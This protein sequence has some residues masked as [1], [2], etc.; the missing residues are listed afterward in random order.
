MRLGVEAV[1]ALSLPQ[2]P[3]ILGIAGVF[4]VVIGTSCRWESSPQLAARTPLFL[5]FFMPNDSLRFNRWW[6]P[7]LLMCFSSQDKCKLFVLITDSMHWKGSFWFGG[8]LLIV[9]ARLTKDL[10]WGS[11]KRKKKLRCSGSWSQI[12]SWKNKGGYRKDPFCKEE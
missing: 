9:I 10:Q 8:P 11:L 12:A 6:Y 3:G 4:C 7:V 1:E 5:G 2:S